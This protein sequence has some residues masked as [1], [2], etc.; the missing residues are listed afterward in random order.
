MAQVDKNNAL[1]QNNQL[2]P[3]NDLSRFGHSV[4]LCKKIILKK[5]IYYFSK[6]KQCYIIWRS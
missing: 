1:N 6:F 3:T 5:I 2:Q 4:T